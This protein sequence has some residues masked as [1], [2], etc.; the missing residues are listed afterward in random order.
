MNFVVAI[1]GPAASGKGTITREIENLLGLKV[2]PTGDLYRCL[3]LEVLRKG[4][5]YSQVDEIVEL[6]RNLNIELK[7]KE[8]KEIVHLNGEDVSDEIREP[9]ISKVSSAVS[10]IVEVRQE[11]KKL[12][13]KMAEGKN[14]IAEGRDMG[15]EIFP[16]ADVKI[17]IDAREDVRARR[18]YEEY[19]A[20]GI[21]TTYEEVLKELQWRDNNDK[22]K[23]VGSLRRADDAILVD[24]TD[25]SIEEAV[26]MI[27]TEIE[28]RMRQKG[29]FDLEELDV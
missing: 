29:K 8:E 12:Q 7:E 9:A 10:S 13:R 5:T 1:D 14:I 25:M 26:E 23:K 3:A 11:M 2:L 18:R 24:T 4:Y 20:K 17:Y 22:N 21:D 19:I 6:A 28:K 16:D 27:K 15:T